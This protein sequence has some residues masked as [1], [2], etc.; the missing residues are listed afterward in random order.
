MPCAV[1]AVTD[2]FV[3]P[4]FP[5]SCTLPVSCFPGVAEV[6]R[7]ADVLRR[8]YPR[9]TIQPVL[10]LDSPVSKEV[11]ASGSCNRIVQAAEVLK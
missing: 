5:Y 9:R 7:Q 4:L 6:E 3:P 11:E 1:L 8:E 2:L 10:V